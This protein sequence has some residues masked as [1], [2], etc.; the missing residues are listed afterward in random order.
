VERGAQHRVD[1]AGQR[2][3]RQAYAEEQDQRESPDEVGYGEEQPGEAVDRR[4][5]R[6]P[7]EQRADDGC[8]GPDQEGDPEGAEGEFQGGGQAVGDQ[9]QDVPAQRDRRAEIPVR[10]RAQPHP[11]LSRQPAVQSVMFPQC[12]D[13]GGGG[14]RPDHHGDGIAGRQAQQR[15]DR[16]S[17][18]EQRH[19]HHAETVAGGADHRSTPTGRSRGR[20]A[21]ELRVV[22]GRRPRIGMGL[23]R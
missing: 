3:Q 9:L 7:P 2:K 15:E 20:T 23:T 5:G 8:R 21:R 16:R 17:D 12:G 6:R 1:A 19:E 13:V 10:H 14:A 18:A 22:H 11:E 4:L